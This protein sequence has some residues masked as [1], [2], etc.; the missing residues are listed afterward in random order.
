MTKLFKVYV[1]GLYKIKPLKFKKYANCRVL[2]V[3]ESTVVV[4]IEQVYDQHDE[5][6]ARELEYRTVALFKDIGQ[7]IDIP[8]NAEL[9][10]IGSQSRQARSAEKNG[11]PIA[12]LNPK[13]NKIERFDTMREVVKEMGVQKTS[14]Y[15]SIQA[16]R[17]LTRG[18]FMNF[19]FF[20][21]TLSDKEIKGLIAEEVAKK[22]VYV[23][24]RNG[25]VRKFDSADECM[26]HFKIKRNR[27]ENM[28]YNPK[29]IA[30]GRFGGMFFSREEIK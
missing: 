11:M 17:R 2:N 30:R 21:G 10:E 16:K 15:M 20:D 18:R 24:F 22:P 13:T 1:G 25:E 9:R 4:E 8:E 28:V 7:E 5:Y 23:Q 27:V 12:V 19:Q 6:L 26:K 14:V 29:K 3:L